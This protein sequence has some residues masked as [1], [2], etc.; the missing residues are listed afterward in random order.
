[1]RRRRGPVQ[2]EAD[3][4]YS[5]ELDDT[6]REALLGFLTE[7]E[8]L[9]ATSPDDTRLARLH[10]GAYPLDDEKNTEWSGYMRPELDASR[11]TAIETARHVLSTRERLDESQV[12]AFMR[13]LNSLRLVLG[14]LLGIDSDEAEPSDEM[15]AGDDHLAAQWSLYEFC[16]WLLEWTVGALAGEDE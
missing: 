3:G 12:M 4:T 7:L 5:V 8:G 11:A 9:L 10:P 2:R 1:M 13:V 6:T 14:T 15:L 16:G